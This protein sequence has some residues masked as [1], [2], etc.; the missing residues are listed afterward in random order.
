MKQ[1]QEKIAEVELFSCNLATPP[2]RVDHE[3]KSFVVYERRRLNFDTLGV[4]YVGKIRVDL[5]SYLESDS[6]SKRALKIGG[7]GS[8][9]IS[10][11]VQVEFG[12]ESGI[13]QFKTVIDGEEAGKTSIDFD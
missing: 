11:E 7:K 3:S 9:S 2:D 6:S 1:G 5:T 4:T 8:Y 13:L 12:N 10:A